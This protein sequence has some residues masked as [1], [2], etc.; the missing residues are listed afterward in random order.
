MDGDTVCIGHLV[1]LVDAAHTAI[2][3]DHSTSL[4]TAVPRI[5]ILGDGGGQTDTRGPT[6][7]GRDGEWRNAQHEAQQLCVDQGR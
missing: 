5:V 3:K 1:K 2:S 4:E 7:R 6:A